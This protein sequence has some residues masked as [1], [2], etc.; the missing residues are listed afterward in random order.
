MGM[1]YE[2]FWEQDCLLVI[3]Y[4]KAYHIQQEAINYE[5]WL[6]GLYIWKALQCAPIFVNGFMP[7]GATIEPY[8]DKPI[9]FMPKKKRSKA[10]ENEQKQQNAVDFM[11][12]LASTFN[13]QFA[14]KRAAKQQS[15]D[16][17]GKE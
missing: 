9:D 11:Q 1:T 2:Q 15:T 10:E 14:A 5:A 7:K 3:P 13:R 6:N 17:P 4:R 12:K 16:P 8:F